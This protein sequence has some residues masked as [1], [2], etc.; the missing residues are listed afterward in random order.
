MVLAL[1]GYVWE[2]GIG[3][4]FRRDSVLVTDNGPELLTTAP[5]AP[6]G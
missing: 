6:V 5:V 4:V 2:A 3:A 1:T